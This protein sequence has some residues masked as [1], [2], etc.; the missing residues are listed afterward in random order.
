MAFA[1]KPGLNCFVTCQVT[2]SAVAKP[3]VDEEAK[4]D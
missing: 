1:V 2:I 3:M 4:D